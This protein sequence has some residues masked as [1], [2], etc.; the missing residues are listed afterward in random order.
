MRIRAGLLAITI[1]MLVPAGLTLG[2]SAQ[3]A[4]PTQAQATAPESARTAS[5]PASSGTFRSV[6]YV[7][8]VVAP[9]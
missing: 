3:A 9:A 8:N 2:P 7:K 1:T 5:A 4:A 6:V